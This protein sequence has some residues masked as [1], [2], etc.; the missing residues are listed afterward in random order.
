MASWTTLKDIKFN[1][2]RGVATLISEDIGRSMETCANEH[3]TVDADG[4]PCETSKRKP[5]KKGRRTKK[6]NE[7]HVSLALSGA[8][9]YLKCT[10][11]VETAVRFAS[12]LQSPTA[13]DVHAAQSSQHDGAHHPC[14]Q[15]DDGHQSIP[16]AM[17]AQCGLLADAIGIGLHAAQ[18]SQSDGAH[19]PSLQPDEAEKQ[20]EN[21][22]GTTI[23]GGQTSRAKLPAKIHG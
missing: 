19:H 4:V 3:P 8:A 11:R 7:G 14:P 10:D 17:H 18:P 12:E 22:H 20:S 2:L 9:D 23:P 1:R 16:Q 5:G 6:N 15:P 13:C 21:M